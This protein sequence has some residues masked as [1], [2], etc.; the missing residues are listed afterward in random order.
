MAGSGYTLVFTA[1]AIL[2]AE[3]TSPPIT[4]VPGRPESVSLEKSALY[5]LWNEQLDYQGV[6]PAERDT[7]PIGTLLSPEFFHV[8]NLVPQ[9]AP[10]PLYVN[11][12]AELRAALL[13]DH[14]LQDTVDPSDSRMKSNNGLTAKTLTGKSVVFKR[15]NRDKITVNNIPVESVE[16][17]SDGIV[18]Y[19]LD[20][21]L[22]DY[23][24]QVDGAFH[25]YLRD[26]S[27]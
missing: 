17:L 4:V 27:S 10:H 15:D 18:S 2:C 20:G 23:V 1:L 5:Y 16:T 13:R 11:R 6:L 26:S 9:D 3:A 12:Y 8:V 21:V 24:Q 14:M 22:F 25:E 7:R 19:T